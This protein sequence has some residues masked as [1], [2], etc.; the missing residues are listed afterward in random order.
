[1]GLTSFI[2]IWMGVAGCSGCSRRSA[3]LHPHTAWKRAFFLSRFKNNTFYFILHEETP[4]PQK[5]M[6]N[7]KRR[8]FIKSTLIAG[9]G[10]ALAPQILAAKEIENLHI[11]PAD[12]QLPVTGKK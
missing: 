11:N 2:E 7:I 9:A 3:T 6:K 4:A 12:Q 10:A 8:T 1:M 5:P